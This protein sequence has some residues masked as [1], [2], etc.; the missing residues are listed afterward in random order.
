MATEDLERDLVSALTALEDSREQLL[1][2]FDGLERLEGQLYRAGVDVEH[3][4][5]MTQRGEW[6][7]DADF[8]ELVTAQA[9]SD[10]R[11]VAVALADSGITRE[12]VAQHLD[13]AS[14]HLVTAREHLAAADARATL[15]EDRAVIASVR[16]NVAEGHHR[17]STA[18]NALRHVDVSVA[19][20]QAYLSM[21]AST[22]QVARAMA[23]GAELHVGE[24]RSSTTR[25]V[26]A[27]DDVRDRT[28][29]SARSLAA[30]EEE[31][32]RLSTERPT[33]SSMTGPTESRASASDRDDPRPDPPST[34]GRRL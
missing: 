17:V 15:S 6:A 30:L 7:D 29:G 23:T 11:E 13:A 10:S 22:P 32:S 14:E 9:S 27:V 25:A 19:A 3:V 20:G 8:A 4:A 12:D 28:T 16:R 24:A 5:A 18:R 31:I 26:D 21:P 34:P 2:T 33:R 1:R